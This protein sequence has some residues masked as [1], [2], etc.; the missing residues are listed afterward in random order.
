MLTMMITSLVVN[1]LQVNAE[2]EAPRR[3]DLHS[4]SIDK[5]L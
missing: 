5:Y 4:V 3:C 2:V 1:Y